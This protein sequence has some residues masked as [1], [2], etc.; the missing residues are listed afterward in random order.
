ML[1]ETDYEEWKKIKNRYPKKPK[2]EDVNIYLHQTSLKPSKSLKNDLINHVISW[3]EFVARYKEEMN[4]AESQERMLKIAKDAA[5]EDFYLISVEKAEN[6]ECIR[7]ILIYLIYHIAKSNKIQLKIEDNRLLDWVKEA[8]DKN[9]GIANLSNIYKYIK[10]CSPEG[11]SIE[12]YK[13]IIIDSIENRSSDSDNFNENFEDDFF[14]FDGIG[15]DIWGLRK[16]LEIPKA[17]DINDEDIVISGGSETP[18]RRKEETNRIIRDTNLS[19]KIKLLYNNRCQICNASIMIKGQGYSEAHHIIPLGERHN[20]PDLPWNI[21]VLC[22]NHHAEFDFGV[23]AIDPETYEVIHEDKNNEY[24]GKI[25]S[26]KDPHQLEK[27][28]LEYHLK[29][30]F[31]Q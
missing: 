27:K 1:K 2:H 26:C 5:E 10:E 7:F 9:G 30:I 18:K 25:I 17:S 14:C 16:Y 22:P 21:I 20:G 23:I 29:N 6:G 3:N 24:H 13:E 31:S 15:K 12:I 11:E 19:K 8:F 28:N 4:S